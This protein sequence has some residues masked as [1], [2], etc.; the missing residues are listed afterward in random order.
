[1]AVQSDKI[2]VN[3]PVK[4]L[5]KSVQFFN[6]VGFGFNA[7]FSDE[8]AACMVISEHIFVMLLS[9]PYFK[10]FTKKKVADASKS[11]EMIL[12]ISASSK[13]SV[14]EIVYKALSS[15]GKISNDPQDH[16]FM[17]AW[18]F[19]DVDGHLW[20]VIYMDESAA[21]QG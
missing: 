3:L 9:E 5:K 8:N 20:E 15:G 4:D 6:E 1:M 21:S 16:G 7:Q 13:E 2:F 14:D 10:N 11:T 19:Q 17:Y 18:S 12:A